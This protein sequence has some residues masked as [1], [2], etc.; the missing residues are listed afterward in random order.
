MQQQALT[1]AVYYILLS[2]QQEH[3]DGLTDKAMPRMHTSGQMYG[4]RML[5]QKQKVPPVL[6]MPVN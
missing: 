6:P 4:H 2:L 3:T 1:E 5:M